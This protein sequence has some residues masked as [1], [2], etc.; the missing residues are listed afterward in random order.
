MCSAVDVQ[1]VL[2]NFSMKILDSCALNLMKNMLAE[3][4]IWTMNV[5]TTISTEMQG[6]A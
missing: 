1:N 4:L 5:K 2:G 6:R 3:C